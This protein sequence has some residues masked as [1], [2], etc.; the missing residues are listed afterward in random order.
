LFGTMT[1]VEMAF[2]ERP[3]RFVQR[4]VD[5]SHELMPPT[6]GKLWGARDMAWQAMRVGLK[7]RHSGP[8]LEVESSPPRLTEIPLITS[9]PE[10]GGAF[11]TLPL[12]LTQSPN[13]QKYNLGIYRL[14]RHSDSELGMHWQ[15]GKGGGFH[16]HEAEQ[17]GRALPVTVFL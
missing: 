8:V 10:D 7:Q 15:I 1:R 3:L 9:W 6:A 12:V 16:Y 13:D 14:Q 11:I 5:L 2:G 17:A 4:A